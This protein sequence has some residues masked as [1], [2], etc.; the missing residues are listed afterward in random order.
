MVLEDPDHLSA[1]ESISRCHGNHRLDPLVYS[2]CRPTPGRRN[3]CPSM[4]SGLGM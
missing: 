4:S 1:D 3:D 2:L